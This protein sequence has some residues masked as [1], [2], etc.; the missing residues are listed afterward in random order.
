MFAKPHCTA[1][2]SRRLTFVV[3]SAAVAA[4]SSFH[5][6]G[7]PAAA[8]ADSVVES[9]DGLVADA[10]G[11]ADHAGVSIAQ[12]QVMLENQQSF[13]AVTA[14]LRRTMPDRFADAWIEYRPYSLSASF[15]GA[16]PPEAE[17]LFDAKGLSVNL[18][19]GAPMSEA[20]LETLQMRVAE[21][22][23]RNGFDEF[24]VS[25]DAQKGQVP[26][27]LPET[28]R[29]SASLPAELNNERVTVTFTRSDIAST[30]QD[31]RGGGK[32][33]GSGGP[34]T[35]GFSVENQAGTGGIATAGHCKGLHTYVW[36]ATGNSTNA[37]WMNDHEGEWGDLEWLTTPFSEIPQFHSGPEGGG[38]RDVTSVYSTDDFNRGAWVCKFG[39]TT[40]YGCA[41][42]DKIA[43]SCNLGNGL[44]H[45]L[46][47]TDRVITN[48]GDSGGPWFIG[49]SAA[50]IH[51]GRCGPSVF[52]K[53]ALLNEAL[54]VHVRRR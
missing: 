27:T 35:A 34:C 22:L 8:S 6:A 7:L 50:G 41:V 15:V 16:A 32:L 2:N 54:G 24:A 36:E 9:T 45:R 38:V 1:P 10:T 37:T 3:A 26:V 29:D 11:L 40:G 20:A 33:T 25:F 39:Q 52:S 30:E 12:A 4:A 14:T 46:V 5:P 43:D 17:A 42:I 23:D 31:V 13:G 21:S 51:A 49:G 48:I 44:I 47:V 18:V 53:V 28:A 19:S